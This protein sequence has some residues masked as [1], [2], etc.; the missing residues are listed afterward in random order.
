VTAQRRTVRALRVPA[1]LT[2]G[3]VVV[4]VPLTGAELSRQIGGGLLDEAHTDTTTA[5]AYTVYADLNRVPGHNPGLPRND[6]AVRLATQLGWGDQ[7]ERVGLFGD[8]LLVGL[9]HRGDDT[10]LPTPVLDAAERV[11][12]CHPM[13]S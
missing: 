6:R 5:G 4:T 11:G 3:C 9:D 8:V 7:V 10:D 2:R 1:D 13:H 12:L